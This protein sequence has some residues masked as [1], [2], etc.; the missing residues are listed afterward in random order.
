MTFRRIIFYVFLGS[1]LLFIQLS[2]IFNKIMSIRNVMPDL[3]LVSIILLFQIADDYEVLIYSFICGF[4]LDV[5][6]GN[7]AG[8]NALTFSI[9]SALLFKFKSL[10]YIKTL[11]FYLLLTLLSLFVKLFI[12]YL[13]GYIFKE[14]FTLYSSTLLSYGIHIVYTLII[15]PFMYIIITIPPVINLLSKRMY[16]K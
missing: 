9:I 10:L 4:L 1:I 12:Y 13:F 5:F 6:S 11:P 14:I 8:L 16:E 3:I 2:A 15:V 7:L